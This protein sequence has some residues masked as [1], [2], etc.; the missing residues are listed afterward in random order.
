MLDSLVRVSRRDGSC[1][2]V[3]VPNSTGYTWLQSTTNN[4]TSRL[5][6]DTLQLHYT[7]HCMLYPQSHSWLL[8][9]GI[10]PA[11]RS[12]LPTSHFPRDTNWLWPRMRTGPPSKFSSGNIHTLTLETIRFPFSSFRYSL[13]LFS[14]FFSSFPH[15]TCSL[16]VSHLYLALDGIYHLLWAAFP[17][18][19]TQRK[20]IVRKHATGTYGSI[21]LYAVLFQG[22][23][24]TAS[25]WSMLL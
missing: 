16:S 2:F 22:T 5:A 11:S 10:S 18:N 7:P 19:S 13:T 15:G 3:K 1:H 20:P 8:K 23:L 14:K 4:T 25:C 9:Y 21:T 6:S 12:D 24:P 17:S